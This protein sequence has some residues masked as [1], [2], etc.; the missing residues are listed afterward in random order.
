MSVPALAVL[1]G[2]L[3]VSYHRQACK[4]HGISRPTRVA[5][6]LWLADSGECAG[7]LSAEVQCSGVLAALP[8]GRI[9]TGLEVWDAASLSRTPRHSSSG[10]VNCVALLP[11]SVLALGL[12]CGLID[13]WSADTGELLDTL[14]GHAASVRGLALLSSGRLASGD[15][16]G[17]LRVWDLLAC[18]C[19][20]VM[21]NPPAW[22]PSGQDGSRPAVLFALAALEGEGLACGGSSG[23]HL[24]S[25]VGGGAP[26]RHVAELRLAYPEMVRALAALPHGLLASAGGEVRVWCAS[27]RACVA[28]LGGLFNPWSLAVLPGGRLAGGD[29]YRG[30]ICV[31]DLQDVF[32]G[33]ASV[34]APVGE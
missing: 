32:T 29:G 24:W 25:G 15:F 19:T 22:D 21:Q 14:E 12:P 6:R 7:S 5:V 3:L 20:S 33:C 13:L 16:S 27:T 10:V 9:F 2:G 17:E 1:D 31:W 8:Q 28:V 34:A 11:G 23:V 30:T 4:P 18:C 26:P